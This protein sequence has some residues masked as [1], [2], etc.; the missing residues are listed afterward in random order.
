MALKLGCVAVL[1]RTQE[2]IDQNISFSEMRCREKQFFRTQKAFENVPERYLG[3]D[4]LVRQL[5][6][7]QQDRIRSTLPAIMDELKKQ[8]KTKKIELKNMP[9]SVT[10]EIECWTIYNDL[11]RR[12]RDT[13]YARVN[14]I[15]DNDLQMK[16]FDLQGKRSG[17][18]TTTT[19]IWSQSKDEMANDHIAFQIHKQQKQCGEQFHELFSHFFTREYRKMVL[20]L[21]EENAGVALPNFPSFTII[22]RLYRGE[23]SKFDGPCEK[24][25]ESCSEYCKEVLIKLLNQAFANET[26]YKNKMLPKLTDIVLRAL[27]ESEEKC[28]IDLQKILCMEQ[29]VF[30]LN[31]Y[32]MDTVNKIKNEFQKYNENIKTNGGKPTSSST[33]F[34][35]DIVVDVNGLSNEHQ[36]AVDVQI[37]IAAYCRVVE[38]CLIDH[39]SQLCYYYFITQC[40]LVLDSK[41]SSAFTSAMLFEW[42]QEPFSQQQIRENLKRSI[43]AMERALAMGQTA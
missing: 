5:A 7:I 15:Y 16:M 42:M 38:K 43:D 36:A 39:V 21:L 19:A 28:N 14:G 4:Q 24:L 18:T 41:L 9:P 22:E 37:A 35:N 34:V 17:T 13:I 1:N 3:S 12:Y 30:T 10:T 23:Q 31:H 33:L 29:R 20:E 8:I 27:D 40:A 6:H 26:N 32:Y 2:E 11:V 25:I